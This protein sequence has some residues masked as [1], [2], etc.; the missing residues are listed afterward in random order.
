MVIKSRRLKWRGHL[1]KMEEGRRAFK[2]LI[3]KPTAVKTTPIA[4]MQ[5][6]T[7]NMS[8]KIEHKMKAVIF[9]QKLQNNKDKRIWYHTAV[10]ECDMKT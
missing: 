6:F 7:S 5:S 10:T 4:A 1:A 2:R 3:G 9:A 8:T